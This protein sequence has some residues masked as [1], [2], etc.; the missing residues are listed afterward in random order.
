MM[1]T[2]K[3]TKAGR[4]YEVDGELYPSVT[5]VLSVISKPALVNWAANTERALVMDA[6]ADLYL[7]TTLI[8]TPMSRPAYLSTLDARLGKTKAHQREL[9]KAADIGTQAHKAI[10]HRFHVALGHAVG[11]EPRLT[12]KSLWAFMAFEDWAREHHV[13]PILVEQTVWHPGLR[14]AGTL[15]VLAEVDGEIAVVDF[16]TGKSIYSE[17]HLQN[18]A[19][20][21]ALVAM[22]HQQP[23][24]G[25]IVRLPKRDDDPAFEAQRTPPSDTLMP[26][27]EA[28]LQV[29]TWWHAEEQASLARWKAAKQVEVTA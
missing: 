8:K 3:D 20:Q 21:T 15:D 23:T 2:R 18:A 29:W 4:F 6:A 5:H 10:E 14:Y 25:Y 12:D 13:R 16:K 9:A 27:F 1:A 24:T 28:V 7:D 19:Y 26:T 11:P 22:G 17:A